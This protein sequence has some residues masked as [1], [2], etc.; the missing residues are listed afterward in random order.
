MSEE[1]ARHL[2]PQVKLIGVPF[3]LAHRYKPTCLDCRETSFLKTVDEDIRLDQPLSRHTGDVSQECM[4]VPTCIFPSTP[5]P[6]PT[7]LHL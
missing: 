6:A 1:E 3:C 4:N 5:H 7:A 2:S